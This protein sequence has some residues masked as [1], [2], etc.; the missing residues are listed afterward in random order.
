[1]SLLTIILVFLFGLLVPV[2]ILRPALSNRLLEVRV[3]G[4]TECVLRSLAISLET[5][6]KLK[7]AEGD[8]GR[9]RPA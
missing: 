2:P 4:L 7:V 8:H 1:M 5:Q 9:T 3:A 6:Q